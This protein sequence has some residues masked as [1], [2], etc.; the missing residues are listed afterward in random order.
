MIGVL[1]P[2][3]AVAVT[4]SSGSFD[5]RMCVDVPFETP[6][7]ET[8]SCT[9][10]HGCCYCDEASMNPGAD[11]PATGARDGACND[12][13]LINGMT[14]FGMLISF[15]WGSSVVA[16]VM[17]CVVAGAV[18]T[19]WFKQDIGSTPVF[20]SFYRAMTTSFGSIALGSLLV[21]ILK[22]TQKMLQEI[23]NNRRD[24]MFLCI[25]DCLL[26]CLEQLLQI[27][28]RYAFCY[29]AIYGYD[30]KTAGRNVFDLFK[31]LGWT[32]II[33]DDLI[34]T[35]L[36]FGCI[37]AGLITG[38]IGWIYGVALDVESEHL[39]FLFIAGLIAGFSMSQV[40]LNVI[41]SA[42]ATIFVCFAEN[43][44]SLAANHPTESAKLTGAWRQFHGELCTF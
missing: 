8:D 3:Q 43:P 42:V 35:A 11:S 16:N 36:T 6:F 1:K 44:Q 12:Q 15:Y 18:A 14:Y 2:S 32:T 39:M 26:S 22:A 24:D 37:G 21:A 33:N 38:F 31:R 40:T 19:W 28:N 4:T 34:D 29:V 25:I 5:S 7:D 20:D 10:Q 13:A 41:S 17:H 27:F 30:F 9:D 23:R